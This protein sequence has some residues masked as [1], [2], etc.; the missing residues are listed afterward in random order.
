IL[1]VVLFHAN[2]PGLAGGFVGVD[3]FFVLSGFFITG[4]LAREFSE[5]GEIDLTDFYGRRGLRLLPPLLVVLLATIALVMLFYAPIDRAAIAGNARWVAL[6]SGNIEFA[7]GA[8]DYFSS[9][10]NPLLHT[11]SLAVEEQFYLVWPLIFLF[12]GLIYERRASLDPEVAHEVDRKRV[13]LMMVIAGVASFAASIWLT[14][15][16]QPWAF[17]GMPTRIWEFAFG[18]A[19]ALTL[20]ARTER[21]AAFAPLFQVAGLAL[22]GLA[23]LVYDKGTAY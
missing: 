15:V 17:Y 12:V 14:N 9:G 22:V 10:E 20:V 13:L 8:V 19:L 2:V 5:S 4:L 11:W 18:G 7:R 21:L 1:L 6:Y 3:V 16:A 23:V